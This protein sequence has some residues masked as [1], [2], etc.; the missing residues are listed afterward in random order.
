MRWTPEQLAEYQAKRGVDDFTALAK[1]KGDN[2]TEDVDH[3]C[4]ARYLDALGVFWLHI[5]NEGKRSKASGARLK[6]MGMTKGASDFLIFDSPPLYPSAK[7]VA[8]ELKRAKGGKVSEHQENW[9]QMMARRGW[10]TQVAHG[11]NDALEYL[12]RLGWVFG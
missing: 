6:A 4:V 11:A 3:L 10:L 2:P 1:S 8:L 12:R 9:L 5:P 7:G